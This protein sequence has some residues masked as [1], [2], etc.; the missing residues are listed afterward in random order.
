MRYFHPARKN[1][2]QVDL[3]SKEDVK[4]FKNGVRMLTESR[5]V[6]VMSS[7]IEPSNTKGHYH[8]RVFMKH[9]IGDLERIALQL[10][11]GDDPVRGLMNWGRWKN[12]DRHPVLLINNIPS[13]HPCECQNT[14]RLPRCQHMKELQNSIAEFLP[15]NGIK[16]EGKRI[17]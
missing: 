9:N 16:N 14:K 12:G 11:L 7:S 13:G 15:R 2:L 4:I 5:H 8:G 3:D 10:A 17:R 1:E 6:F